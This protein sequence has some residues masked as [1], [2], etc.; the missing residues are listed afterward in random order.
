[1]AKAASARPPAPRLPPSPPPNPAGGSPPAPPTPPAPRAGALAPRRR[2][3]P[4]RKT[5][6]ATLLAAEPAAGAAR[7]R[8]RSQHRHDL[9]QIAARGTYLDEEDVDRFLDVDRP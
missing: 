9:R 6:R 1:A 3:R 7:D 8:W 5:R 2:G 4:P